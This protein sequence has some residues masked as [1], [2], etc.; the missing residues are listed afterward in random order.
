MR[1]GSK[2]KVD[3]EF[4]FKAAMIAGLKTP[5]SRFNLSCVWIAMTQN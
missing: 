2:Q 4:P 1:V 5:N 3:R